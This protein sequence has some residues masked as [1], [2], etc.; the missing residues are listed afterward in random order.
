MSAG[1]PV[2]KGRLQ[3]TPP[4]GHAKLVPFAAKGLRGK[5]ERGPPAGHDIAETPVVR[6]IRSRH[7]DINVL[8][9]EVLWSFDGLIEAS[10][11]GDFVGDRR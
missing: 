3:R 2:A 6:P 7:I 10:R 4:Q 5:V 11:R 1:V 9:S 8:S